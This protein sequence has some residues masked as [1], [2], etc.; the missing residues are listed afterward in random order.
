MAK[1]DNKAQQDEKAP[2]TLAGKN[3]DA[4]AE[5]AK[6]SG[7]DGAAREAMCVA[8][9]RARA[10]G[11]QV[12]EAN[13][14]PSEADAKEHGYWGYSPTGPGEN[15]APWNRSDASRLGTLGEFGEGK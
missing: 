14:V 1:G 3:P 12:D 11:Y 15:D 13:S 10:A 4:E 9:T 7:L 8:K 6:D 2:E 5:E